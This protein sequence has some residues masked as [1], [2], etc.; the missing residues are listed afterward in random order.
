[1]LLQTTSDGKVKAQTEEKLDRETEK[2]THQKDTHILYNGNIR[3]DAHQELHEEDCS[4]LE[5]QWRNYK[6]AVI[7]AYE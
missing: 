6:E 1:M 4:E 3:A 7:G 5:T 2:K